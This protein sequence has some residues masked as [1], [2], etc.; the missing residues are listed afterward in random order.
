VARWIILDEKDS[1]VL[2]TRKSNLSSPAQGGDYEALVS[3]QS[4]TIAALSRDIAEA[5]KTI[6][7]Q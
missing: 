2:F 1:T 7:K 4:Q 5:L 6:L 3:A